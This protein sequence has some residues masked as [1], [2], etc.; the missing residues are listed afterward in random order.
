MPLM[1]WVVLF[2]GSLAGALGGALETFLAAA[3]FDL[4]LVAWGVRG[5]PLSSLQALEMWKT[6]GI[7]SWQW[8]TTLSLLCQSFLQ[9]KGQCGELQTEEPR[10]RVGTKT[11]SRKLQICCGLQS[12]EGLDSR[13]G[14]HG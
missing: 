5:G 11:L 4:G 14:L 2:M 12:C 13:P 7:L 1:Y 6:I 9:R 10:L 3:C 8:Q